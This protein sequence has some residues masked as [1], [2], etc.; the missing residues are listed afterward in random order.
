MH[1]ELT[2]L[3]HL[4]STKH[5]LCNSIFAID[6]KIR[7]AGILNGNGKL[8]AGGMREGVNSLEDKV[9]EKRWYN[10]LTIRREMNRMFDKLLGQAEYA[11][12]VR[13]RVKQLIVYLPND[14]I[15]FV[16]MEPEISAYD[17]MHVLNTILTPM[18]HAKSD[19]YL[20]SF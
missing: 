6:S 14:E 8:I 4:Y 15:L 9:S 16:S 13:E 5:E 11:F 20:P 18:N 3:K 12:E 2:L 19:T 1:P 10:Q 17:A 7:F